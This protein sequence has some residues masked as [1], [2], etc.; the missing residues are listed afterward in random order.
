MDK[1][2]ELL[3][4]RRMSLASACS[5]ATASFDRVQIGRPQLQVRSPLLSLIVSVATMVLRLHHYPY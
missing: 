5:G 3:I 2:T 1:A 4:A